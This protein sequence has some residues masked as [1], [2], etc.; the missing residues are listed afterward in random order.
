M[1]EW[2]SSFA[3]K[4]SHAEPYVAA[5]YTAARPSSP[6]RKIL[7]TLR[8]FRRGGWQSA[9]KGLR[10]AV[11]IFK[12]RKEFPLPVASGDLKMRFPIGK[13]DGVFL[14]VVD[15]QKG[16]GLPNG[17]RAKHSLVTIKQDGFL[18]E[19]S[20]TWE[21]GASAPPRRVFFLFVFAVFTFPN[22]KQI[23]PPSETILP[24]SNTCAVGDGLA[25]PAKD[26]EA[27]LM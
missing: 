8:V 2:R 22:A 20:L 1:I 24:F 23:S 5:G 6:E 4:L 27:P 25:R 21:R 12:I 26:C 11:L 3:F 10:S 17:D 7:R 15:R 19:A 14:P 9:R 16:G 13:A 18:C